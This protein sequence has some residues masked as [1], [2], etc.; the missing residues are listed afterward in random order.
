[1][2]KDD[3]YNKSDPVGMILF[4]Q[5]YQSGSGEYAKERR[6]LLD[7][8]T[9]GDIVTLIHEKRESDPQTDFLKVGQ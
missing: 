2:A 5:Q 1:M 6:Q 9:V 4:L 3:V 8:I 7:G